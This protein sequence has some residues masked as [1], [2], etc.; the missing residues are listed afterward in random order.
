MHNP[1]YFLYLGNIE[2]IANMLQTIRVSTKDKCPG[3]IA[4]FRI[5]V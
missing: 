1:L 2:L 5:D 3:S 4:K